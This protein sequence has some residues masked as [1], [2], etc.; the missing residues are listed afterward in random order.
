MTYQ[1][2][3]TAPYDTTA[4]G[5]MAQIRDAISAPAGFSVAY[6]Y[7]DTADPNGND[8][9]FVI[10]TPGI[11]QVAI[12][13]SGGG[14]GFSEHG[15]DFGA[16]IGT[17]W[18]DSTTSWGGDQYYQWNS[19]DIGTNSISTGEQVKYW[20]EAV[21]RGFV[22]AAQRNQA[23][24]ND[25]SMVFAW[26]EVQKLWDY[27]TAQSRE[28]DG[29][30]TWQR[31]NSVSYSGNDN[32]SGWHRSR[33]GGGT[34][35]LGRGL[36]NPDANFS[37][38]LWTE[39]LHTCSGYQNTDTNENAIIGTTDLLLRE[40]SSTETTTGDTIQDGGGSDIYEIVKLVD[41]LDPVAIRMD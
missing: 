27:S 38:Y 2:A 17:N 3:Q 36:L 26:E 1:S 34:H 19:T 10:D 35:T 22:I 20:I 25:G 41:D 24:G 29:R 23:D 37:N 30:W 28:A 7:I 13:F 18:D 14:V 15:D 4:S 40:R 21:P 11:E 6:D 31:S 8:A 32:F 5:W 12:G 33:L 9:Y 16:S 39:T